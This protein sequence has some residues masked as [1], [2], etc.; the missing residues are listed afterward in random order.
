MI[1]D[2]G[3]DQVVDKGLERLTD[4][5]LVGCHRVGVIDDP[6]DVHLGAS[7]LDELFR[8]VA[9]GGENVLAAASASQ[10]HCQEVATMISALAWSTFLFLMR[11]GYL[12][13]RNLEVWHPIVK[14][15]E[16]GI[17]TLWS[18]CSQS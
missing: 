18:R 6:E 4:A 13:A 17:E 2:L 16:T 15:F 8:L 9:D 12:R 10:H 5:G 11:I 1:I 3:G 7:V 14:P